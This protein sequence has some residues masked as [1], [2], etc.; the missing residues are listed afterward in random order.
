MTPILN[1]PDDSPEGR[2]NIKQKRARNTIERCFG[3]LKQ[4]FRCLLKHRVL[5]Y[6]HEKAGL[7]VYA[8]AALHNILLELNI[9]D[10]DEDDDY[11]EDNEDEME[12]EVFDGNDVLERDVLAAGR[13]Q[14]HRIIMILDNI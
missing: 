10:D 6:S 2:Y 1:V 8:C 13:R 4:R 3:K 11:Y 12:D 14:R 7:I 5:H 9:D